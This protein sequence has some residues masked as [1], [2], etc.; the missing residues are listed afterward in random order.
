MP[1]ADGLGHILFAGLYNPQHEVPGA[2][3]Q[4]Y[5]VTIPTG[6]EGEAKLGF[7]HFTLIGVLITPR[8]FSLLVPLTSCL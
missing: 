8:S 1:P 3:Y 7:A 5:T 4:N 2:L 6:L